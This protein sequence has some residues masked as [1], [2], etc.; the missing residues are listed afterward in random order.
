[1]K[2]QI[3]YLDLVIGFTIFTLAL[4]IFFTTEI[5]LNDS[6]QEHLS[7]LIFEGSVIGDHLMG[8]GYPDEWNENYYTE[9]GIVDKGLINTTKL[10]NLTKIPY[11]DS[12]KAFG[13]RFDYYVYIVGDNFSIEQE[14]YGFPEVNSSSIEEI[15]S[16][17]L[18]NIDRLVVYNKE[19]KTLKVI[20]WD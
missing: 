10:N 19:I 1:M 7:S 2:G 9:I 3:W 14:G 15:E 8:S 5:N 20:I 12:K 13:T 17:N 11:N 6:E 4:L 18:I 16:N